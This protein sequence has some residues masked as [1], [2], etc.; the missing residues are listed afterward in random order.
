MAVEQRPDCRYAPAQIAEAK[1]R[2]ALDRATGIPV[3]VR[4]AS[5]PADNLYRM[6]GFAERMGH[7]AARSV[8]QTDDL[9]EETRTELWNVMNALQKILGDAAYRDSSSTER[10]VLTAVWKW[11]YKKAADERPDDYRIWPLIKQTILKEHFIDALDLIENI[12]GYVERNEDYKTSGVAAAILDAYNNRFE[13]Y[14]VGFR[15]IGKEVTPVDSTA[16]A[17]AV[18]SAIDDAA[19]IKGAR[20]H[21]ERAVELLADRQNPDYPNSIKESI[22]AVEAVCKAI[23]GKDTLGEALKQLEPSGVKI[24]KALRAAWSSMY[25]YTSDADGIRHG[26]IE[27][28]DADQSL[29]K[30]MLVI[31]SAFVS[32]VIEV[33]RKAGLLK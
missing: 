21:L 19:S 20:H 7:R 28:P 32:H 2:P 31:C 11:E 33:S 18:S 3:V 25:G 27:A 22:S 26:S 23:T 30:Y 6:A 16:E 13:H 5:A 24:H 1:R 10:E 9:D 14:L 17:E 4:E 15:F 29:A 8:T 12:L